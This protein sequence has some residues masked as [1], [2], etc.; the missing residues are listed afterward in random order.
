M[1]HKAYLLECC[2]DSV[3]SAVAAAGAGADR[4]ELCANLIIGGTTPSLALFEEVR[5]KTGVRVHILLRP[6]FGDF[7]YSDEEFN[8]LQRE[9]A[10][11]RSAGADGIVIGCL[12]ADGRLDYEKLASLISLAGPMSITLHR[13]FDMCADPMQALKTAQKLGVSTILTSGCKASAAEGSD[14]LAGLALAADGIEIMAGAGVNAETIRQLIAGGTGIKAF[15]MS[16]KKVVPSGMQY[17]NPQVNM[18]LPGIS[19]YERWMTDA[20][21]ISAAKAVLKEAEST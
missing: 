7:L 19:E 2:V 9:A 4:L 6:R 15:H 16:G 17:R 14:N 13:A 11:F 20:N 18:G 21:A 8:I 5:K 3:E 1:N 12:S 10:L